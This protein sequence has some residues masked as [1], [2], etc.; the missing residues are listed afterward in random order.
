[1]NDMNEWRKK[2]REEVVESQD[3]AVE[4]YHK[5]LS[6]IDQMTKEERKEPGAE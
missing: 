4:F 6:A 2:I 3:S 5:A 1:M